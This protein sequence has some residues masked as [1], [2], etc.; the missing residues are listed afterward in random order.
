MPNRTIAVALDVVAEMDKRRIQGQSYNAFLR[1]LL[2]LTTTT[3]PIRKPY[4]EDPDYLKLKALKVG[5]SCTLDFERPPTPKA[6]AGAEPLT[7]EQARN[8][9]H[10]MTPLNLRHLA[11]VVRRC[12]ERE[13]Y[14][15]FVEGRPRGQLVFRVA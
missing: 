6:L 2:G 13:G 9:S 1:N 14:K 7:P 12:Q 5:E 11:Q 4:E 8:L 15:L 3:G 10:D